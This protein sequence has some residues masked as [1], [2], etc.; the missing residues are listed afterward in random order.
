MT[1]L[2]QAHALGLIRLA[3]VMLGDRPAAEDAVQEAFCGLYRRWHSLS[4][5]GQGAELRAVQ[6]D[7]RLP[8]GTAPPPRPAPGE[9]RGMTETTIGLLHPGEMGAAVGKCLVGR[10]AP[11]AVGTR[12]TGR[13]DQGARRGRGADRGSAG[14]DRHSFGCHCLGLPAARC[15]G[16]GPAGGRVRAASTWTPTRSRRRRRGRSR[17][18]SR[19]AGPATWTAGSSGLPRWRRGSPGCTCPGRAPRRYRRC[20]AAPTWTRGW[21]RRR[22][23]RRR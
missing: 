6:R 2:Y 4:D 21:C 19:R 17:R 3:V 11:G 10:R 12:G 8:D 22:A 23:R 20:S 7:Q 5:T 14:G 13:G 9:N 18:S 1:A 16:R 15:S